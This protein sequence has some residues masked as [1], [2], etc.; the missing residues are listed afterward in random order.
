MILV[1]REP[2]AN[3]A[4]LYLQ[5][6]PQSNSN[7]GIYILELWTENQDQ[8]HRLTNKIRSYYLLL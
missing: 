7:C 2:I 1:V 4:V 3:A 5:K 8:G 6:V